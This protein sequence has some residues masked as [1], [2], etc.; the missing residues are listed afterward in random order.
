MLGPNLSIENMS[1]L[2]SSFPLRIESDK[3]GY[4]DRDQEGI[5]PTQMMKRRIKLQLL[6]VIPSETNEHEAYEEG[7]QSP[8]SLPRIASV[9]VPRGV[10]VAKLRVLIRHVEEQLQNI[11]GK[12]KRLNFVMTCEESSENWIY[13]FDL[14]TFGVVYV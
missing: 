4:V 9:R 7:D 11:F 12:S 5:H 13:E 2:T 14:P 3:T 6:F 1:H 8:E 10:P